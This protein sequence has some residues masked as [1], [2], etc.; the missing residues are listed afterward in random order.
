MR[1][2]VGSNIIDIFLGYKPKNTKGKRYISGLKIKELVT[3]IV[4]FPNISDLMLYLDASISKSYT[5]D[6]AYKNYWINT[7]ND[8]TK[9]TWEKEPKW[10]NKGFFIMENRKKKFSTN[11]Q[12]SFYCQI[13][14]SSL[15]LFLF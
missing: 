7:V 8:K 12:I 11:F 9:F 2:I 5:N 13:C 15:L 3:D 10:D 1:T 14:W 4:D 6:S